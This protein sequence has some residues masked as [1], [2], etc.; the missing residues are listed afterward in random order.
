MAEL[1]HTHARL[2]IECIRGPSAP[3]GTPLQG[4]GAPTGDIKGTSE[5]PDVYLKIVAGLLPKD[6]N[7][8]VSNLDDLTDEQLLN[9]LYSLT[10]MARPL[11][12]RVSPDG[13]GVSVRVGQPVDVKYSEKSDT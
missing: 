8:K 10:E 11:L 9:K 6:V 5:K 12:A 3:R 13:V 2:G 7:L 4:D 1:R